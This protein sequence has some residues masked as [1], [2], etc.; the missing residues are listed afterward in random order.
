MSTQAPGADTN[1]L[2]PA[3]DHNSGLL[4]IRQPLS[5][6]MAHGMADFVTEFLGFTTDITFHN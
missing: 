4:D 3:A 2:L 5:I 1:L 6:S